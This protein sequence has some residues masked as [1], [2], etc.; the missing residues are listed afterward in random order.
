MV[1]WR[2]ATIRPIEMTSQQLVSRSLVGIL[3]ILFL[4]LGLLVFLSGME[5]VWEWGAIGH[6]LAFVDVLMLL[7]GSIMIVTAIWLFIT[8]G[9]KGIA[10]WMGGTA[11][12]LAGS[13]VVVGTV[14]K[15]IPCGGP[16]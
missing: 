5:L 1:P 15:V 4:G 3:A 11:A 9:R 8:L 16:A 2:G 10:L 14:S 6:V 7:C 12:A 13:A